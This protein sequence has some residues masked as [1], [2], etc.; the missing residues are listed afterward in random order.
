MI[1]KLYQN[2][3]FQMQDATGKVVGIID[4]AATIT[5]CSETSKIGTTNAFFTVESF[6]IDEPFVLSGYTYKPFYDSGDIKHAIFVEGEEPSDKQ[7]VNALAVSLESLKK[8]YNE[9]FDRCNFIKNVTL[10]NI[11]PGDIFVKARELHFNADVERVAFYIKIHSV[12]DISARDVIQNLF[13]NKQKDFIFAVNESDVAL[14]KEIRAG[15]ESKDLEQ[16]AFSII[17]T[18]SAEFYT[19]ATIGIGSVVS[20]IHDLSASF[21]DATMSLEVGKVF[22]AEKPII[23]HCNLGIARLIYQLP[24]TL[25]TTFLREVFKRGSIESTDHETLFTI[26]KFFEN[27]LNVSETSRKLFVH[28]NTLVYRLEKIRKLTGLDLREFDHAITFKI[29]MMV[30]KYLANL[31]LVGL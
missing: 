22:D 4:E 23:N 21:K 2:Y 20:G 9:K 11:L 15:I 27:S 3:V 29:A 12:N 31:D 24:T 18:L 14:I 19:K 30:Q 5:A 25:C 16:L 6:N 13:P 1:N 10:N 7:L 17:D 8:Y 26:Q 28:R